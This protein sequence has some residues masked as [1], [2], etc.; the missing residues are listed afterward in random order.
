M[1]T[2]LW[3]LNHWYI[4]VW[5][6]AVVI[7][8]MVGG[9]R[10]ALALG[11]LGLGASAYLYGRKSERDNQKIRTEKIVKERENAYAEIDA[12]DTDR[13]DVARRLRDG[14]Y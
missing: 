1:D 14:S 4:L 8:W 9:W 12:R 10:L 11:T 5:F 3:L 2:I 7:G 13:D 6:M